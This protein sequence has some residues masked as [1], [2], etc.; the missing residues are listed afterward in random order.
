[1]YS[2]KKLDTV[3]KTTVESNRKMKNQH[4]S[5]EQKNENQFNKRLLLSEKVYSIVKTVTNGSRPE[6]QAKRQTAFQDARGRQKSLISFGRRMPVSIFLV[7]PSH[8]MSREATSELFLV[9]LHVN[10]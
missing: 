3:L 8:K 6:P 2:E 1:M 10:G 5:L 7:Q 4:A 9:R